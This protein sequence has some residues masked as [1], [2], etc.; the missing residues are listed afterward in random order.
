MASVETSSDGLRTCS[1]YR[2]SQALMHK[3][4][5]FYRLESQRPGDQTGE[6]NIG[7]RDYTPFASRTRYPTHP[8]ER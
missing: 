8:P 4:V 6:H 1:I 3:L 7:R 2:P 5:F